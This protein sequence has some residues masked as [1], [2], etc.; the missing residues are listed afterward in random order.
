MDKKLA[1]IQAAAAILCEHV[2]NRSVWWA[3]LS[4]NFGHSGVGGGRVIITCA[5]DKQKL[6]F[7]FYSNVKREKKHTCAAKET[8]NR[9]FVLYM[10]AN[11][12]KNVAYFR[13]TTGTA[14]AQSECDTERGRWMGLLHIKCIAK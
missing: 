1:I 6:Q 12:T 2:G 3:W 7:I 9:Q 8:A 4:L 11:A 14:A 10:R 13:A 5:T